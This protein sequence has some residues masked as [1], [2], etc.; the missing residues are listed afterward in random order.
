MVFLA[1]Y[2]LPFDSP[3]EKR[4]ERMGV[5]LTNLAFLAQLLILARAF[6][7]TRVLETLFPISIIAATVPIGSALQRSPPANRWS[8]LTGAAG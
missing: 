6:G 3:P 1:L 8:P 4:R 7:A 2:R 5:Y